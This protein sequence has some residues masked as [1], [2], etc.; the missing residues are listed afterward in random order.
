MLIRRMDLGDIEE[1]VKLEH[2][3]F[4][5]P[6]NEEAFKYELEKNAF[7][8]ILILEDNNIIVGYI[9]MW[10]LGDQTQI[11]TIGVRKEF[12]GKGYAKILMTK[13]D[14]ITKHLGYSNIN[15]EVRVSN[16]RI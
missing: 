15:L 4:S 11:T 14:E 8:S 7:S 2:D 10:T 5:S 6:W 3:L 12:Q 9:G 1:V 13:C 16:M